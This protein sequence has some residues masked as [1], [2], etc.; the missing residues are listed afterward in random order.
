MKAL[1]I[2]LVL[3]FVFLTCKMVFCADSSFLDDHQITAAYNFYTKHTGRPDGYDG[4]EQNKGIIVTFDRWTAASFE[5][6]RYRD[7][8]FLG[9]MWDTPTWT[10][11]DKGEFAKLNFYGGAV[12]GY[13]HFDMPSVFGWIPGCGP[14]VEL[15]FAM[16]SLETFT[17]YNPFSG[18]GLVF[19]LIKATF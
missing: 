13:S 12:H 11:F 7:G 8:Y 6:T 16:L 10:P 19:S 5:T 2:M 4:N 18:K 14:S 1:K 17:Y 15:G 3:P 9:Y